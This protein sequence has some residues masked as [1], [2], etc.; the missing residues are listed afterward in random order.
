M[1]SSGKFLR[2]VSSVDPGLPNT[3]VS[4]SERSRSYVTSR[5]VFCS[6]IFLPF[7]F[8]WWGAVIASCVGAATT[9]AG[10]SG[11]VDVLVDDVTLRLL[12]SFHRQGV[13]RRVRIVTM[14]AVE[15]TQTGGPEV[16]RN[17]EKP[18]PSPGTGEV[19]IKAE[20]IGVN[21]VDTY[22]RS[23]SYPR[24]LPFVLGAEVGGTV[25]A[26]GD[27]ATALHARAPRCDG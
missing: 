11:A 12:S 22:F 3:V 24:K 25:A 27:G 6:A 9:L 2:N 10:R 26:V 7:P 23:G 18:I 17:V 1:K 21:F 20:A 5:M 13:N 15:V 19:F 14:R 16:L 4:S 8:V